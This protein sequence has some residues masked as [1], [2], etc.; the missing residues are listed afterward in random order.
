MAPGKIEA[1]YHVSCNRE[2]GITQ[3]QLAKALGSKPQTIFHFIVSLIRSG[4]M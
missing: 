1:L 2:K 3:V 4:H